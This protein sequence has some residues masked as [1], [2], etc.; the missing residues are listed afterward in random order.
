MN[1]CSFNSLWSFESLP[2]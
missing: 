2:H 1:T